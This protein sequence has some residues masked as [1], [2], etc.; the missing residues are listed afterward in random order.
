MEFE[1]FV[2]IPNTAYHDGGSVN[3]V[4]TDL[5]MSQLLPP[6]SHEPVG[7]LTATVSARPVIDSKH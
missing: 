5:W 7:G 6:Q 4:M 2:C 1:D 3:A